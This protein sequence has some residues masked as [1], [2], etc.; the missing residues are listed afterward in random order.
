M[1]L[2]NGIKNAEQIVSNLRETK[3]F[4]Y[5]ELLDCKQ[6]KSWKYII[7]CIFGETP[8]SMQKVKFDELVGF[9]FDLMT[10]S[11][12]AAFYKNNKEIQINKMEEGLLSYETPEMSCKA[13]KI[14]CMIRRALG[15]KNIKEI[16]NGFIAFCQRRMGVIYQ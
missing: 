14:A 12:F 15:Q 16:V 8:K 9:N 11:L 4:S 10:H 6:K 7:N 13:M 1:I 2:S 3:E 5:V